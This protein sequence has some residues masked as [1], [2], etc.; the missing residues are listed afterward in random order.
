MTANAM[1]GDKEKVLAAGM[2]DHIAKP[3]NVDQMFATM[4]RWIKPS[5]TPES[6]STAINTTS[7]DDLPDIPGLNQAAGLAVMQG[8]LN[9]YRKM[10]LRFV[11]G[12]ND[13]VQHFNLALT[14]GRLPDATRLAHTLKGTAGTIG[15]LALQ[16]AA[17]L[18]EAD[19]T[20]TSAEDSLRERLANVQAELQPLLIALQFLQPQP[21]HTNSGEAEHELPTDQLKRLAS[22]L[23]ESD[24]ES[25]EVCAQLANSISDPQLQGR[26]KE[27][28]K[29]VNDFDFDAALVALEHFP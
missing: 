11:Q 22:L 6:R 26:F 12:Q 25:L 4:A 10:L 3:L 21:T 17:E 28:E 15:A 9:L 13:F 16:R 8:N 24:A 1:A 18:L 14:E 5:R 19:C 20:Q 29:L 27:I 7:A 2:N 23:R